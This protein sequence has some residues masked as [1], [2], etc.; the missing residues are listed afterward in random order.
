[1]SSSFLISGPSGSAVDLTSTKSINENST[2]I[3]TFLATESATWSLS[4]ASITDTQNFF[5]SGEVK[6]SGSGDIALTFKTQAENSLLDVGGNDDG[7]KGFKSLS[8]FSYD[9][10]QDKFVQID[11]SSLQ[12]GNDYRGD[13]TTR[14]RQYWID[15]WN[16][17]DSLRFDF[18]YI[19]SSGTEYLDH[20][21]LEKIDGTFTFS[22]IPT[23][24]SLLGIS[25]LNDA[26]KFSIDSSSGALTFKTAPDY[27]TPTDS[28]T[29]ND[30]VPV[31]KASNSSGTIAKQT[32]TI[33]VLDV[34]APTA[35]VLSSSS[36]NEN[37]AATST[38]A[39]LTT[40]DAD[41][42][43]TH[44][45]SFVT[46]TGDTDN[47]SFT[48]DGTSLKIKAAPDYETKSSY[49][50]RLQTT[51]SGGETYAKAFTLSVNDLN[52]VPTAITL[53]ST[54]FNE[55][56]AATST[57]ATLSTTDADSSDTHTYSFVTGTGDTD[58]DSFTIDGTSLKIKAAPDYETKSSYSIRLQTTDSG[59]K[60]AKAFSIGSIS[61]DA[62]SGISQTFSKEAE[63][64]G[65]KIYATST[66]LDS[67]IQHAAK[68]MAEYLDN[69]ED[70]VAD[71]SAVITSMINSKATLVM[72][73]DEAENDSADL[74]VLE[75]TGLNAQ[76][77]F[78][79][80]TIP[81]GAATGKF[82]ASLEEVL[83]LITDYGYAKVYPT[84]FSVN[85]T[86]LLTE[87][88][89]IARGGNFQTIPSSYP[90]GAWYTYYD[91]TSDYATQATEYFYWGLTSILGAQDFTGRLDSIKNE[92][93][94]NTSA[95]VQSTDTKLYSLLTDTQYKLPTVLPNGEYSVP[96]QATF[97]KTLTVNDLN[98][99][100]GTT[101]KDTITST[102][103]N[104]Y[105]DG[106]TETDTL[107]Y[108]GKFSN[109]SFTRGTDTLQISDQRTTG[110]TDGTDTLKNIEYI[111]FSDQ[112]VEESKVDV[113]KTYTG[114]FS[115]Y[116]FYNK[117]NGKYEIKTDSGYDDITGYPSL[118]FS[119]EASTS[120]FRDVSAIAD[121][122]GT[123]DQVT[124]LD[125]DSGRMFRLYNASF[126]RLP[127]ADGLKYWIGKYS[128][129]ENDERAVAQSFLVS[130]EFKQRYGDN[131]TNAKYVETLYTNVLGR[132]YDQ[133]GYNYW[134]GNLNNGTETRHE[135]LLGFAESAE[136]KTLFT[137]MTGF[138]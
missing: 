44:T 14:S 92:W 83:H 105:L 37:V 82:D 19:N 116:K 68:I 22:D 40:T 66:T 99:L 100:S 20:Y 107:I 2:T 6:D 56:V 135:L 11:G 110:T 27:E 26:S 9:S 120:S 128:S 52:E 62:P 55:N 72:F 101:G 112:T 13:T 86:S 12:N 71:D 118:K 65:I 17:T 84:A 127:D 119:G 130:A 54:S 134:L 129:G 93:T 64:F 94:P 7:T 122:K 38:V 57:V 24:E 70:G 132:D 23:N 69:D 73:K 131:V 109:Y 42:S 115:D 29:N 28:D 108:S 49:S 103:K 39:T 138:G 74:S 113:V 77:L 36:F 91:E 137:E 30:Y 45:Y 89:D 21:Y 81:N 59:Q 96:S 102:S 18:K 16:G 67:D 3:H 51:D 121:I 104:D 47:D 1:M 50:I 46:G 87:A 61:S 35:L 60:Q 133:E 76:N 10:A 125:T 63:V 111:Q 114:E 48:I 78:G 32:V 98:E 53:S 5:K 97:T 25:D 79:E 31:V 58:N 90:A 8:T 15:E 95:K 123:F 4:S 43:D 80:E 124:G 117:G 88:M 33:S 75:S 126:K 136:N 41:S 106:G 34:N 85:T